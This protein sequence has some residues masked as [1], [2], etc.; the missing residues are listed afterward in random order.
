MTTCSCS[1]VIIFHSIKRA[2]AQGAGI[3]LTAEILD[4]SFTRAVSSGSHVD[5][6]S[7][8]FTAMKSQLSEGQVCSQF[9]H[10]ILRDEQRLVVVTVADFTVRRL[11]RKLSRGRVVYHNVGNKKPTSWKKLL[12]QYIRNVTTTSLIFFYFPKYFYLRQLSCHSRPLV[13]FRSSQGRSSTPRL[14]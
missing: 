9:F 14:F 10:G 7:F 13:A 12:L 6:T 5:C 11:N 2:T 1:G 3:R 8:L 4:Y